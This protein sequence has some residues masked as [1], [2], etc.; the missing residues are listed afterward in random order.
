MFRIA[1]STFR[2]GEHT[3]R[4]GERTFRS[5]EHKPNTVQRYTFLF[6]TQNYPYVFYTKMKNLCEYH[7][8]E[9]KGTTAYAWI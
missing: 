8:V 6:K 1:V 2:S 9:V 5:A 4:S 3:F 7:T